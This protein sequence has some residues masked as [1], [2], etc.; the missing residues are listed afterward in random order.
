MNVC[1][2][3]KERGQVLDLPWS[4]LRSAGYPQASQMQGPD[5]R[6]ALVEGQARTRHGQDQDTTAREGSRSSRNKADPNQVR[7]IFL[8]I[9]PNSVSYESTRLRRIFAIRLNVWNRPGLIELNR[10]IYE[11]RGLS[12]KWPAVLLTSCS[13]VEYP[14]RRHSLVANSIYNRPVLIPLYSSRKR[15]QISKLNCLE[16]CIECLYMTD[17]YLLWCD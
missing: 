6:H 2:L 8:L 14:M 15:S 5:L 11:D 3:F 17:Q 4:S 13:V 10:T 12:S 16:I 9:P 1:V 7:F